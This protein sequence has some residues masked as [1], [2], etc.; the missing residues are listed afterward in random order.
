MSLADELDDFF[1]E[2]T[3]VL[4]QEP[5]KFKAMLG[6][7][8]RA[9]G[10]LRT[11]E[12][13]S[14]FS[15]AIG[16]G[17]TASSVAASGAVAGM[18]FASSGFMASTLSAIGLGATAVTPVGWVIAAGVISGGAYIGVSRMFEKS[19]DTGLVVV[20][21]YINTPLDVIAA[22]LIE[23]MLPVSLKMAHAGNGMTSAER[24]AIEAYFT[25][26]WGYSSGFVARLVDEYQ[27]Q[28]D[29]V[30]YERLA[31]S[32]GKYCADSK[33]C[34]KEAIMSGFV[35]HLREVIEAD[36]VIDAEEQEQLDYLTELLISEAESA[37]A[38]AVVSTAL[39]NAAS[40]ISTGKDYALSTGS[41]ALAKSKQLAKDVAKSGS[42]KAVLAGAS[43]VTSKT[44]KAASSGLKEGKRVATKAGGYATSKAK[45]L[46]NKRTSK[47]DEKPV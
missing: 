34:D 38:G 22:A 12:H 9:Y 16:F 29:S 47:N 5:L 35:T 1:E 11:R 30:S 21:K 18:F 3:E 24:Q 26:F 2:G 17:A 13:M 41:Q 44:S 37:G 32:L 25:D 46:W 27:E 40:G 28:L 14:T 20:P 15:E 42:A 23:L 39:S 19:K 7:G 45:S 31:E 43:Q 33:D 36:G 10:L 6:I 8:E 4:V